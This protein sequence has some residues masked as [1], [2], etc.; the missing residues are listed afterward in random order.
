MAASCNTSAGIAKE[1]AQEDSTDG[2]TIGYGARGRPSMGEVWSSGGCV[3]AKEGGT[4]S[5]IWNNRLEHN[6]GKLAAGS[7]STPTENVRNGS[8]ELDKL[9]LATLPQ[10]LKLRRG[11][12]S[13]DGSLP[14]GREF[15]AAGLI[16]HR[17]PVGLPP[18]ALPPA[19]LALNRLIGTRRTIRRKPP[20]TKEASLP[21][22]ART[23][24]ER[25]QCCEGG[26][27]RRS[28]SAPSPVCAF[29]RIR[30][31]AVGTFFSAVMT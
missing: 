1:A 14:A 5:C 19:L 31:E 7:L 28:Q 23:H 25:Q 26:L 2:H 27:A 20:V 8:S 18:D 16:T 29:V 17:L 22:S 11:H 30:P 9:P 21:Y 6:L 13:T 4:T 24:T 12:A 3:S 10:T 15:K